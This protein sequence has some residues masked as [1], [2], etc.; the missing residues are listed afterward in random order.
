LLSGAG[1]PGVSRLGCLDL[2]LGN[3]NNHVPDGEDADIFRGRGEKA[4][5]YEEGVLEMRDLDTNELSQVYGAGGGGRKG[6]S[7][8]G[9]GS[10][11]HK[12]KSKKSKSCKSKSKRSKKNRCY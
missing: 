8:G 11:S 7:C 4:A 3:H 6:G 12:S 9:G 2:G 5:G 1:R 10:R